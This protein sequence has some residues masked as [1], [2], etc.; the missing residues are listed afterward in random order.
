MSHQRLRDIHRELLKLKRLGVNGRKKF[1]KTCTNDC[2]NKISEC[3][4]NLLNE[5]ILIKPSHLKKLSRHKH[6]LRALALKKT[7]LSKRKHLIQKGGFL[8]A[9]LPA[10]IPAIAGLVRN[11]M[12]DD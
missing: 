10:L 6:T 2:I 7:G 12:S 9:F 11:L 4:K 3:A 1:L 5:N 8:H